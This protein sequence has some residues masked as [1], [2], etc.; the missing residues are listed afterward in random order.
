MIRFMVVM[1]SIVFVIVGLTKHDW[2]EA[3]LFGLSVAVGLT[4]EMLPM[5]VTVNLVQRR[6]GD[7]QEESHREASEFD[8]ELR[9]D[10][11]PLHGQ[12]R[13]AHAGPCYSRKSTSM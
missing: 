9:R 10:R 4:P 11:H 6:D 5:I 2:A 1:V 13:N 12:D 7:V 3:L 8:P